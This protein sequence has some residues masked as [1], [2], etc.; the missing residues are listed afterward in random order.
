M[1]PLQEKQRDI[2]YIYIKDLLSLFGKTEHSTEFSAKISNI[3]Y[4]QME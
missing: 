3:H 1:A 4:N 2:F